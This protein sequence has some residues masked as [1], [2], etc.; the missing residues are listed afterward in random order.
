M[1]G[2]GQKLFVREKLAYGCGDAASNLFWKTFTM[3]LVF[4]Y[5]DVFG[6]AAAAVGTMMLVTR[7]WDTGFDPFMGVI[8]DRTETRWGKFRP[9]LLWM[10]LPFGF[11]GVLVMAVG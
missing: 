10:A 6:L 1:N 4:F 3:F 8:A 11:F 9:Y 2:S 5:T 7:V